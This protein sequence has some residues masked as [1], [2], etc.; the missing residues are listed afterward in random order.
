MCAQCRAHANALR[1]ESGCTSSRTCAKLRTRRYYRID[2]RHASF[3]YIFGFWVWY[4]NNS[5]VW[6]IVRCAFNAMLCRVM[7]LGVQ[8]HTAVPRATAL[9]GYGRTRWARVH[10]IMARRANGC[11]AMHH[12]GTHPTS[13]KPI[14]V[15]E[16]ISR[17][18]YARAMPSTRERIAQR[19]RVH[20]VTHM[21]QTP[22]TALLSHRPTSRII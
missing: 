4:L 8:G 15:A 22:R 7:R 21:Y 2:L 13:A 5:R 11:F 12:R 1:N 14:H 9:D 6:Y 3:E 18:A 19:E 10:V 20:V 17:L 16:R